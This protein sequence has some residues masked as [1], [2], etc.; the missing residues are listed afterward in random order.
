MLACLP[1]FNTFGTGFAHTS[2][3]ELFGAFGTPFPY[4]ALERVKLRLAPVLNSCGTL[5]V[6]GSPSVVRPK[7]L[8]HVLSQPT[9]ENPL[10]Q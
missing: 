6:A 7:F 9:P 2:E 4:T 5:V 1:V 3:N 8:A 10:L